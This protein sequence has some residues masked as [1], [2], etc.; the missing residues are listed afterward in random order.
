MENYNTINMIINK[1]QQTVTLSEVKEK[2]E[3]TF[4]QKY[5][6]FKTIYKPFVNVNRIVETLREAR[7]FKK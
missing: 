7:V 2:N 4:Q 5:D 6:T 1:T 3:K